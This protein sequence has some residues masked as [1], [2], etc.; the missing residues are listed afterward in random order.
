MTDSQFT[1]ICDYVTA[2]LATKG[3]I[4]LQKDEFYR[5]FGLTYPAYADFIQRCKDT[6]QQFDVH[7][8]MIYSAD[9][10]PADTIRFWPRA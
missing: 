6:N 9:N 10:E 4:R 1:A 3:E 7:A 8:S 2:E 5:R